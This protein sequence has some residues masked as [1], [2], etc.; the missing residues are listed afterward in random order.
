[1]ADAVA[2]TVLTG[3]LG[4]GKTTLLAHLLRD[5]ELA[6]AA[7]LINEFGEAA[8]D[9]LLVESVDETT[10]VLA[11]GC[12]CCSVLGDLAN[13]LRGL[14]EKRENGR[15]PPFRRLVIETTGLADPAPILHTLMNDPL[16][17]GQYR[18]DGIA[19]TV[20]GALG[21]R[22][23][24]A[25]PEAEKQAALAERIVITKVDIADPADTAALEDRLA[26]LNPAAR[27]FRATHGNID[28]RD[29]LDAGLFDADLTPH[30]ERWLG[31]DAVRRAPV[32]DARISTFVLEARG[33][34]DFVA[35]QSWLEDLLDAHG[36]N[37]LRVKGVIDVLGVDRPV[38]VHGVQHIFHPPAVLQSW[39]EM[40][41]K[42]R[43]V[44][45]TRGIHE[46]AVRSAFDAHMPGHLCA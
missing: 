44:F 33:P 16:V 39:S 41:K 19:A 4:S 38:A 5:P 45:I 31:A 8:I 23:L 10:V 15:V 9:H 32:H 36:A 26:R 1:M 24:A 27:I 14:A 37:V 13:A 22:T 2:V 11:S 42:S 35:F 20:D 30:P 43:I 3:F 6:D 12:V 18:L 40:E 25:H 28:A 34:L 46:L 7:V 21:L 29:I 17:A